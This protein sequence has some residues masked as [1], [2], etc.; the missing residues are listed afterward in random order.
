MCFSSW[1]F[2]MFFIVFK[3]V[4]KYIWKN[5]F[6]ESTFTWSAIELPRAGS[7]PLN[8]SS[9]NSWQREQHGQNT[10]E[11]TSVYGASTNPYFF[12]NF[13]LYFDPITHWEHKAGI[14]S[15]YMKLPKWQ[16]AITRF[17]V[18]YKSLKFYVFTT[19][20]KISYGFGDLSS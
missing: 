6:I 18:N 13:A 8:L 3:K 19:K 20:W 9:L 4:A 14:I 12:L 11:M 16:A 7:S 1:E 10:W 5:S 17:F 2:K 15:K